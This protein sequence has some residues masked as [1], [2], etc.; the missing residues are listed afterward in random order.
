[1]HKPADKK[2]GAFRDSGFR[3]RHHWGRGDKY[4]GER[5]F[6]KRKYRKDVRRRPMFLIVRDGRDYISDI[7]VNEKET[8]GFETIVSSCKTM[9]EA[10]T[11]KD[12]GSAKRVVED[13]ACFAKYDTSRLSLMCV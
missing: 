6:S 13:L 5:L 9:D 7:V 2:R 3:S 10:M 4:E 1:M 12:R 8:G 11:F